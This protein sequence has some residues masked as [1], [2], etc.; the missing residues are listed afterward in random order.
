MT[1]IKE[2]GGL[3]LRKAPQGN[4]GADAKARLEG[5]GRSVWGGL[6]LSERSLA[7]TA[8]SYLELITPNNPALLLSG[9][10][11]KKS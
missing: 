4:K 11:V 5:E 6:R 8:V 3:T 7:E 9:P 2:L 10:A 1:A